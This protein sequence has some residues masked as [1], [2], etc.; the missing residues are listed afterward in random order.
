MIINKTSHGY[1]SHGSDGTVYYWSIP[2]FIKD[3]KKYAE[4]IDKEIES[5]QWLSQQFQVE[6]YDLGKS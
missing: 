6:D 1:S 2:D 3:Q 5:K 4:F